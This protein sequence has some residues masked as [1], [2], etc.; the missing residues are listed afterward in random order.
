M[1]NTA[2]NNTEDSQI[3]ETAFVRA[4]DRE[5]QRETE[6]DRDREGHLQLEQTEDVQLYY[7]CGLI[8]VELGVVI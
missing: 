4:R 1:N 8:T 6:T 2:T 7:R 5:T 3:Q